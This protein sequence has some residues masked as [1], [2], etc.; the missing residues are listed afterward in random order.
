M[1]RHQYPL[2]SAAIA[3]A[4]SLPMAAAAGDIT[5]KVTEASTGRPLP[6]A[7]VRVPQ[8]NR[9]VAADRSGEYRIEGVPAGSYAVEVEYVGIAS[10]KG[11]VTVPESG[12]AEQNFSLGSAP[13]ALGVEEIT[14]TGYRLAQ[15][16]ALQDKKASQVIKES[17]TAD[18]AGKL[19]DR[20][21]GETLARVVGVAVTTDQGEG[22]YV[23]IRG[24]DAALSNVTIDG[25]IIGSPKA[26]PAASRW[27]PCP[28]TSS[29]S[30][31]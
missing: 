11:Q 14:V 31:R 19:P 15:I 30:S 1:L 2:L 22:R 8:L 9:S 26:T 5:G 4:L 17:V 20:N 3:A 24:I 18:D 10:G 29:R 25:Q 23:T 28:R 27:T 21:A 7:T 6:N 12:A 13:E 16:T